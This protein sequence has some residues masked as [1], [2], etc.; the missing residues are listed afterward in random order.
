MRRSF[1]DVLAPVLFVVGLLALAFGV[2]FLS[3]HKGFFP[4]R[5]LT[6]LEDTAR[7]F[8]EAYV[9][10]PPFNR[11]ARAGWPETSSARIL[12]RE[13]IAGGDDALTFFT[14]YSL[15]DGFRA[16]LVDV[17][18]N[19]LHTWRARFSEVF[20][21]AA[22]H[23]LYQA[24]DETISWHG[25]HLFE[26]G[27]IVFNFQDNSFPYGSGLVRLDQDSKVVWTLP[28]NTHHDV[29]L[30]PDGTLWVPAHNYIAEG[31]PEF[32]TLEPWYYEDTLLQVD[33]KDGRVLREISVLKAF[34][35]WPG[36]LSVTY[37]DPLEVDGDDPL[38]LNNVDVLPA[39]IADQFP[40]LE[41]GD[42]MVSLRNTNTIAVI[43]PE[44][45]R[46]S[47]V[48]N[49]PFVRQHDPDFLPNGHLLVYDNR[50]GDP[51]C[52]SDAEMR[53]SSRILEIDP[54]TQ[55]IV[56]AYTGCAGD[57]FYSKTRGEQALLDNGNVLTFEP[58]G[59][60]IMEVTREA[61]PRLVWE[62]Y[63]ML[64][65]ADR[66]GLVLH[67][68]RYDREDLPFLQQPGA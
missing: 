50:G 68:Q 6:A 64:S 28:R 2:G 51:S 4:Y 53:E 42:L 24:R 29:N 59:G 14:G 18:G 13:A 61:E 57:P 20:G 52:G 22:E 8:W 19:V 27:D 25:I 17:E 26:N 30:A 49:G 43:D 66:V 58:H 60:R 63:N 45:E 15:E 7:G 3:G 46:V 11:P 16:Q 62:Y 33:P 34:H 39:S 37:V 56:W 1:L 40:M 9:R 67:A 21:E 35:D 41:A 65:E 23:L 32:P 10:P 44:T 38:H 54:L 36:A 12:D 47:W 31:L 48:F 5:Q 55:D